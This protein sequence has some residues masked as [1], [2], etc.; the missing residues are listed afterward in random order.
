MDLENGAKWMQC[1]E[2]TNDFYD[3]PTSIGP[4]DKIDMNIL[5][6]NPSNLNHSTSTIPVPSARYEV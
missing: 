2:L 4:K 6:Q 1:K 3:C 5:I